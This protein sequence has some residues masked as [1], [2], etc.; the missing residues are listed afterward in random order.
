M[1]DS[2]IIDFLKKYWIHYVMGV[3]FLVITNY[4][5]S[6]APR[7]LG[8]IIDLLSV[9]NIDTDRIYMEISCNRKLKKS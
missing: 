1:K 6:M 8:I 2:V 3:V 4:I 5:Q 9:K 7:I